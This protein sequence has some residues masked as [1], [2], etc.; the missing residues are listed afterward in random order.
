M[1]RR[2]A[3]YRLSPA[4]AR[5]LESIWFYTLREWDSEQANLYLDEL[6]AAFG[7]LAQHP[8]TARTCDHIRK[9]YRCGRVGRHAIYFRETKYGIA[10]IRILHD[11]MDASRHL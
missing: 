1:P 9:G 10:V 8:R 4:A 5:D 6:A 2:P 11:R 7:R 3:E